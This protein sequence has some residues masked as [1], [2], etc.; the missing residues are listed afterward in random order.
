MTLI[1]AS[2]RTGMN[3][4]IPPIFLHDTDSEGGSYASPSVSHNA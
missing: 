2:P 3:Q 1:E 4:I